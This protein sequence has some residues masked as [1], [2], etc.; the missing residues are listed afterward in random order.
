VAEPFN[1]AAFLLQVLLVLGGAAAFRALARSVNQ[2]AV[3]GELILGI[4]VGPSFL[5]WAWPSAHTFF[6]PNENRPLLEAM[7]WIGLILFMYIAGS[8]LRWTASQARPIFYVALGGLVVPFVLGAV[9][10]LAAPQ[11]FFRG[12]PDF[13]GVTLVAIIM[14]VSALPILARI[15]GDLH[16]LEKPVGSITLG[17]ATID[18]VVGWTVLGMIVGGHAVGLLGDLSLNYLFLVGV[19][20][21][22]LVLDRYLAPLFQR[23]SER[24]AP[25]L[26]VWLMASI[27]GAAYV[28]HAAGLH[29]VLGPFV[30]G[31]ITSR[32]PRIR[33]YA[34]PRLGEITLV[35]FLPSF[36]IL[37]GADVNLTELFSLD[38][39]LAIVIVAIVASVGK[40]FGATIGGRAAKLP[41]GERGQIGILLNARGAVGLVAAKVGFDAHLL[42]SRGFSLLVL[43]IVLTTLASPIV[44]APYRAWLAKREP[45]AATTATS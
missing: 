3:V 36:F 5:V 11:W 22:A 34:H 40:I 12:A 23:M 7:G 35:L 26:F 4:L 24:S 1:L 16:L 28:T 9:L 38:G 27:F 43:V 8:E 6:F 33:E 2:P 25:Y 18:D 32:H 31:A 29:A 19:F 41:A 21:V 37:A 39:L 45:A 13:Q 42:S 14:T 30:V 10:S 15:L 44:L 20:A 17:A